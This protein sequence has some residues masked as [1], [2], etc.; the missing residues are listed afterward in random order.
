MKKWYIAKLVFSVVT[1]NGNHT[2]QF[3]EQLRLIEARNLN[4]AFLKARLIGGREE[5]AFITEDLNAV[6]WQF[7]D[8]GDLK[9]MPPLKDGAEIYSRL[10]EMDDAETFVRFVHHRAEII[11]QQTEHQLVSA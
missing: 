10:F 1:G 4:E 3:D 6:K 7:V 8:I 5:E 11:A 2:P 9:E